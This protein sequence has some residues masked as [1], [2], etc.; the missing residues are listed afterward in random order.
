MSSV[1]QVI[2]VCALTLVLVVQLGSSIPLD[3]QE[4]R[5]VKWYKTDEYQESQGNT[6]ETLCHICERDFK[7]FAAVKLDCGDQFHPDCLREW[8]KEANRGCPLCSELIK[9]NDE[10]LE[11][12]LG[13]REK[14]LGKNERELWG[15]V[16]SIVGNVID[17]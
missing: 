6:D 3:N 4:Q 16:A 13:R 9:V 11:T 7:Q 8:H 12:F 14:E 17:Y 2:V 1:V 15:L 10:P 5:E